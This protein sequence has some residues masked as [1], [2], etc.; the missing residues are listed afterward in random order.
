VSAKQKLGQEQAKY[1]HNAKTAQQ[2]RSQP[3]LDGSSTT[4]V[5]C[6]V[7]LYIHVL[8]VI[9]STEDDLPV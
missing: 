8:Y 7:Y 9:G 2:P 1:T 3:H 6:I 4:P 5:L